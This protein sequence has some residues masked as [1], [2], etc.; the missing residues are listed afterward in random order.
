MKKILFYNAVGSHLSDAYNDFISLLVSELRPEYEVTIVSSNHD[1]SLET[2]SS[3]SLLHVFGCWDRSAAHLLLKAEAHNLPAVY[4]PLGGLQPW[5]LKRQSGVRSISWQKQ[6]TQRASAVHLCGKLE[7]ETF[8]KLGWNKRIAIIKNPIFTAEIT[9]E[10]MARQMKALY[11]KVQDSNATRLL[12]AQA[13]QVIG[14]L[15]QL[16][17]DEFVLR[18]KQHCEELKQNALLLTEE[19]WRMIS[20]YASDEQVFDII[21]NGLAR[22]SLDITLTSVDELERF[23][24]K[25]KYAIGPLKGDT[26]LSRN[27]LMKGKVHD[28][29]SN[30]EV[31]EKM[32]CIQVANLKYEMEHHSAPLLH[33]VDIY[34]TLRFCDMDEVRVLEILNIMGM[35]TFASHL[36]TIERI[37]LGLTEGFMPI[38]QKE[39]K[40]S[41]NLLKIITKYP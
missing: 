5:I 7:A 37:V 11:R 18:K 36:M 23:P 8:G 29:V 15:L 12:T 19:D 40:Q 25:Q 2:L 32:F 31:N 26:L 33:L 27:I 20:I 17:V 3:F 13:Q 4:S 35:E 6:M 38:N 28:Y 24:R 10:E 14:P 21:S 1:A 16:G 22:L 34:R 30:D 41:S 39:D 9:P